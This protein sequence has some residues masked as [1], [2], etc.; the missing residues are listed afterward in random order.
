MRFMQN[1]FDYHTL[2]YTDNNPIVKPPLKLMGSGCLLP[3]ILR[4]RAQNLIVGRQA[5]IMP[6][7]RQ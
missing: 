7:S 4:Q 6:C 5:P 1:V 2:Y 3:Q